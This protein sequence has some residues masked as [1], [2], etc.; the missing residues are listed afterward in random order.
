VE[1]RKPRKRP[2]ETPLYTDLAIKRA[3]KPI[4]APPVVLP[5]QVP[6]T[7]VSDYWVKVPSDENISPEVLNFLKAEGA[8][9]VASY[10]Y[11]VYNGDWRSSIPDVGSFAP[12][13]VCTNMN[14]AKKGMGVI[15][16]SLRMHFMHFLI[17]NI[18]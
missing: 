11:G 5:A 15:Y 9:P 13:K 14:K 12:I 16:C 6:I 2:P 18:T 7:S 17:L 4:P 1:E 3:S 8:T 10:Y